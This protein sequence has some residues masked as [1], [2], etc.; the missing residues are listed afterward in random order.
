MKWA[1]WTENHDRVSVRIMDIFSA[2]SVPHS[3][4]VR[5]P[6]TAGRG[7]GGAPQ[8]ENGYTVT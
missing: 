2:H 3:V 7:W 1:L 4:T 8:Y 5:L 6:T